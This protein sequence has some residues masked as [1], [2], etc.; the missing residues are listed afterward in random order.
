SASACAVRRPALPT[1][2]PYTTLFRS[3]AVRTV[4]FPS[5]GRRTAVKM[6]CCRIG[7]VNNDP[8]YNYADAEVDGKPLGLHRSVGGR[9]NTLVTV[10]ILIPK[11]FQMVIL[12]RFP[13]VGGQ[14]HGLPGGLRYFLFKNRL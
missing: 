5:F 12:S 10:D 9:K 4:Y 7:L 11:P 8:A 3:R 2:F 13:G 14:V 6:R 1:L